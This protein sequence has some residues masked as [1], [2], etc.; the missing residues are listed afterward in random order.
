[1]SMEQVKSKDPILK[2]L[3]NKKNDDTRTKIRVSFREDVEFTNSMPFKQKVGMGTANMT[4]FPYET[5]RRFNNN[6]I[7]L[8]ESE[9]LKNKL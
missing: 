8:E 1:M 4:N 9:N 7:E 6:T 5:N 3:Y 2:D